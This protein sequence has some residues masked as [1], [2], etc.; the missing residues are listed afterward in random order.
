MKLVES[1][2]IKELFKLALPIILGNLG[3]VMLGAADCLVAGRYSTSALAA[4]SIANSIHSILVM[5]GVGL[6]V[7]ISPLLS[8]K[9]GERQNAKRY[10]FPS[11]KFATIISIIMTILTLA[12]I[13]ALDFLHYN[14]Q[15]LADIKIYTI[16]VAFSI[17]GVEINVALKEFLQSYEIVVF[18]NVL[19]ILSVFLNLF[20]NYV[21][22]FGM[23]GI[24]EMGVKGLAI[25]TT[26]VRYFTAIVLLAF[27]FYKFNF[28]KY[29]EKDYYKQLIKI[30]LP[31]SAAIMIEFISFN[32]IA[33][34]LG[35]FSGIY[36]AA[37]NIMWVLTSTMYMV[38]FSVSN[39]L[40]VKVGFSNGAK[41]Y[42]EMFAYIRHGLLITVCFMFFASA[43][44]ALFP[45]QCATIFTKDPALIKVIVPIMVV[46]A[47]FQL[48][49]G[50]QTTLGGVY[51][52]I[53]KT[54][55]ILIAN[56]IA[57]LIVGVS[58][59]TYLS[60]YKKMYLIGS[61]IGITVSS[62]ILTIILSICLAKILKQYKVKMQ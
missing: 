45:Y 12:Y 46:V 52:G 59:G 28:K 27:C 24:P 56:F 55:F 22:V 36:A 32:Y 13:P 10:F 7:G 33:I 48:T 62:L 21:F 3:V 15:L 34:L 8:N 17:L 60:V 31:I 43:I 37:H 29:S 20:L 26:L 5:F 4:I 61:W 25:A 51:K 44:F 9:R 41:N 1:K 23:F 58:L 16:I 35:K 57:Y 6:T 40:A 2:Y 50:L 53:K 14:A 30:G 11:L 38:P 54:K 19:M 47:I 42:P 18:P 39:A 49:D